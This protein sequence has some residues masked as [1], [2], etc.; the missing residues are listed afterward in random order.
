MEDTDDRKDGKSARFIVKQG[1]DISN[2]NPKEWSTA[3][4]RKTTAIVGLTGFL[5]AWSSAIDSAVMKQAKME[6]G[7]SDVTESLATAVFLAAFGLGALCSGPL[8]ETIGRLQTYLFSLVLFMVFVMASALSPNIGAQ[9]VFRAFSGFF[10]STPLTTFGGSTSDMWNPVDRAYV[11]PVMACLSFLGPFLA[12][13]VGSYIGYTGVLSWRW[14]EWITLIMAAL[15]TLLIAL[16]CPETYMP[17]LLERRAYHFR[18]CTGDLRFTAEST[19]HSPDLKTRLKRNFARPFILLF[20]QY[21]VVF[22]SIYLSIVYAVLFGFLSGYTFIFGD[23][24]NMSQGFVG[25]MFLGMNVGFLVALAICPWIYKKY[26]QKNDQ[27]IQAGETSAPP[28]E[29]LWYAM[30]AAPCFAISLFWMG[31]TAFPTISFWSPLLASVMFGFAVQG[32]FVSS[33]LYLIDVFEGLAASALVSLT[34]SRYLMA[35]GMVVVATPMYSNLGVHWT[36]TL[37]GCIGVLCTPIPYAFYRYGHQIRARN[38][39]PEM[40]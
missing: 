1:S 28:E 33:Y 7:V 10:G 22:W 37:L 16:F 4:K 13:L 32:I 15:I 14:V 19:L 34:L 35:S 12:P 17:T 31:W 27:A 11:F 9:I 21:V 39:P 30:L 8:S 2:L 36:L 40:S 25:L 38:P 6:F 18:R 3:E 5:V 24:Y 29:R 20:S 26:K 23:T